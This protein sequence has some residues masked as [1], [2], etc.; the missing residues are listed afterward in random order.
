MSQ[1]GQAIEEFN[2]SPKHN[3]TKLCEAFGIDSHNMDDVASLLRSAVGLAGQAVGELISDIEFTPAAVAYFAG[4]DLEGDILTALRKAL[5]GRIE[6]PK[7]GEQIDRIIQFFA[8]AYS[9][10][11][12]CFSSTDAI[13]I[14]SYAL[15]ML[16]TDLHNEKMKRKMR[17]Q[18]FIARI[19]EFPELDCNEI[20][21][22]ELA[23]IYEDLKAR[24]LVFG[25]AVEDFFSPTAP[26][27]KG[28]LKKRSGKSGSV[29][30]EHFFVLAYMCLFYYDTDDENG[31]LLGTISL[32]GCDVFGDE[33]TKVIAIKAK[34]DVIQY[35]K[36]GADNVPMPV[37][38]T[39]VIYLMASNTQDREKWLYKMHQATVA[40]K[41]VQHKMHGSE[42]GGAPEARE[43]IA[44]DGDH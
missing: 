26:K 36:F 12:T 17:K 44:G 5:S 29:W 28:R 22:A 35:I 18:E 20:S 6:F 11:N 42:E 19:R 31:K 34:D 33:D 23:A 8:Q 10:Q 3:L 15:I 13:Y 14:I 1:Q 21:D 4:M 38:D 7:E 25:G 41:F 37:L 32:E 43:P 30:T 16:N 2:K 24:P 39:R 40:F 27:L 9:L